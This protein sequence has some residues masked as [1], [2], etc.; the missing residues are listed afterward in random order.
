VVIA[1][2]AEIKRRASMKEIDAFG[3]PTMLHFGAALLISSI[4][5][6]PWPSLASAPVA[7]G[8]CGAL[9]VGYVAIVIRRARRQRARTVTD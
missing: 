2:L 6:A 7:L 5:S 4:I 9:G 3:T 8:L 1:L